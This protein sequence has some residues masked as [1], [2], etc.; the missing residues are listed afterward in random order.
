[1]DSR[2]CTRCSIEKS[3]EEFNN[4]N[5]ECKNCISDRSLGCYYQNKTK[6]TNKKTIL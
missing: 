3:F 5:T 4:K 2:I 6:I 1:M